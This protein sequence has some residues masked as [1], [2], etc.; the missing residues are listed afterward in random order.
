MAK[1][2]YIHIRV[3]LEQKDKFKQ[4][5]GDLTLTDFIIEKCLSNQDIKERVEALERWEHEE[6]AH[7]ILPHAQGDFILRDEVLEILK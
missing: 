5:A 2:D 6:G 4:L 3:T 7:N 1:D